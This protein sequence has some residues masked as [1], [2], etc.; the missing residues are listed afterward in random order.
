MNFNKQQQ[1]ALRYAKIPMY[2][3]SMLQRKN[4]MNKRFQCPYKEE[5]VKPLDSIKQ[6]R[7]LN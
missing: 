3:C 5:L 6:V 4:L 2:L 1:R 7:L